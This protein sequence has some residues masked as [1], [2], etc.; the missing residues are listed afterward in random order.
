MTKVLYFVTFFLVLFK[1]SNSTAQY[2]D[3]LDAYA[4]VHEQTSNFNQ[5]ELDSITKIMLT[6]FNDGVYEKILQ[7]TPELIR[8]AKEIDSYETELKLRNLL[9]NSFVR[10]DDLERADVFFSQALELAKKKNDTLGIVTM[11]VNL[12]N[13]YFTEDRVKAAAYFRKGLDYN[14]KGNKSVELNFIINHNLAELYVGLENVELTKHFLSKIEDQIYLKEMDGRRKTFIATTTYIKA[15]LALLENK[16]QESIDLTLESLKYQKYIDENYKFGNYKHLMAG[17][18]AIKDYK[19]LNEVHKVYDSLKDL[20]NEKETVKQQQIARVELHLDNV[21]QDLRE[22]QLENQLVTQK[23]SVGKMLLLFFIVVAALLLLVAILLLKAKNKRDRLVKG[24]I[25][26][27]KQYLEAK[28]KSEELANS[29]TRFLSTIS[30]EL[31][32]PLYGIVGLTATFLKDPRL[33]DFKNEFKSLKF[34]ADY[35]LALVNDVLHINKFSSKEGHRLTEV[36]FN[37]S[38]LLKNIIQTFTFLNEKHNNIVTKSLDPEVPVALYGDKTKISQ[39]LMN[40]MSNASKFTEDGF[41]SLTVI[42]KE[43]K[44]NN[45]KL[46]FEVKDSGKGIHPDHQKG[47]FEEFTQVK[48]SYDEDVAGTGLG[49]PIVNKILSILGS[50]LKMN[51]IYNKGTTFSFTLDI[52][53]GCLEAIN[54][55]APSIDVKSLEGKKVLIVD[56]NK[57]NQLV[58][59]KVL[60]QHD[61]MHRTASNGKEAVD[62]V[63]KESFDFILM[64][65]NMPVM[66]GIEATRRIREFDVET[67]IIALTATN[68]V[69]PEKEVYR[70]GVNSIIVKPYDTEHLLQ[71]L[72]REM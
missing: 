29:N 33:A 22:S 14:Y 28:E 9:G 11:Y 36:H 51:S 45:L 66:N 54:K 65:I 41:I 12:G 13:T 46:Y 15:G 40:L 64:D 30:H 17:Y 39:V 24:L 57:I 55:E 2:S 47:I 27:N 7:E 8:N 23:A 67:P 35:L 69:D 32:T 62:M 56:D 42:K 52:K 3:D 72:L 20:R 21:V 19:K 63:E 25:L 58:T 6:Y 60:E 50:S 18:E 61:M 59:Q 10:L 70:H 71:A 31:R 68:F 5:K 16:P 37:L 26:K 1:V 53:E 38:I 34:S 4:Q 48:D 43:H 44:G 49:L